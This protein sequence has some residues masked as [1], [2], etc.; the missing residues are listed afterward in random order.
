MLR[1]LRAVY[2]ADAVVDTSRQLLASCSLPLQKYRTPDERV[3]FYRRLEERL[4]A[5][6]PISA[7]SIMSALP[8]YTAPVRT[9][10]VDGGDS[11]NRP[12]PLTASYVAVGIRYFDALGL[13]LVRGRAFADLDGS[14][15]HEAAIVNQRFASMYVADREP[16][17]RR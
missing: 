4:G 11:S 7:V 15:G 16:V 12:G 3:A 1:T 17:G 9:V 5:V 6:P 13:R 8:F 2:R 14:P 10:D